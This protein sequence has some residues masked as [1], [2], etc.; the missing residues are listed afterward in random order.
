MQVV[1][2]G[3]CSLW[4]IIILAITPNDCSAAQELNT[5]LYITL[6]SITSDYGQF[7]DNKVNPHVPHL[8]YISC[9]PRSLLCALGVQLMFRE[10]QTF[11]CCRPR[12]VTRG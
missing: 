5:T 2:E 8:R 7:C 6:N 1:L 9:T 12:A 3:D 4:T 11:K 10:D